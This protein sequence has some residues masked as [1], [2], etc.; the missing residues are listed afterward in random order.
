MKDWGMT[1][2]V[3]CLPTEYEALPEFNLQYKKKKR[4]KRKTFLKFSDSKEK[5]ITKGHVT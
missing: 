3:G 4:K 5:K 2:V 1:L